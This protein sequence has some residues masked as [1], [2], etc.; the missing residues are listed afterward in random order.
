V[1]VGMDGAIPGVA[2][3]AQ[4]G[5]TVLNAAPPANNAAPRSSRRRSNSV[6]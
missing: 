3:C 1:R 4:L 6:M 5:N 2:L